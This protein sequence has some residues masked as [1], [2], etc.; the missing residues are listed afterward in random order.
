LSPKTRAFAS[1][2]HVSILHPAS[3]SDTSSIIPTDTAQRI[4]NHP[5]K[6]WACLSVQIRI[7]VR[8]H[9]VSHRE[10]GHGRRSRQEPLV[11]TKRPP[12]KTERREVRPCGGIGGKMPMLNCA[13]PS[14]RP[15]SFNSTP[16]A[17]KSPEK[18]ARHSV[19]GPL[20]WRSLPDGNSGD[21]T[22][23]SEGCAWGTGAGRWGVGKM[24]ALGGGGT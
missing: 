17:R 11:E 1:A 15:Y 9:A 16:S 3:H 14:V 20:F 19:A 24:L 4:G 8:A 21:A 13:V 22:L 7:F 2:P 12:H 23:N 10:N 6:E 18:T 5:P